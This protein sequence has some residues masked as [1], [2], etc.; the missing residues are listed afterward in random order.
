MVGFSGSNRVEKYSPQIHH[1]TLNFHVSHPMYGFQI[2]NK[3]IEIY[4]G[5]TSLDPELDL[6]TVK[7]MIWKKFTAIEL[8][9]RRRKSED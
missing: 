5:E 2:A 4:C 1:W 8:Q 3:Q 7:H 9:Y 6:R